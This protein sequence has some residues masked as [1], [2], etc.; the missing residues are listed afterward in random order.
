LQKLSQ[1]APVYALILEAVILLA[2]F[3]LS[4]LILSVLFEVFETKD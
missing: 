2:N 1:L 3:V 4:F